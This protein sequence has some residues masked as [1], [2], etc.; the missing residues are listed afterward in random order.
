[1]FAPVG[2][3]FFFFVYLN[4][5]CAHVRKIDLF[6]H[7]RWTFK[8]Q[9]KFVS[10][11]ALTLFGIDLFYGLEKKTLGRTGKIFVIIFNSLA[12]NL[13]QIKFFPCA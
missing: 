7:Y 11:N 3:T 13:T 4:K 12:S 8:V 1:M 5:L 2:Y 10:I 9:I 6:V